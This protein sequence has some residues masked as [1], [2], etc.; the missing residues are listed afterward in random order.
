MPGLTSSAG[1]YPVA[2][3]N[4]H[5]DSGWTPMLAAMYP[6]SGVIGSV[7][8]TDLF[9]FAADTTNK[10]QTTPAGFKANIAGRLVSVSQIGIALSEP[11][12]TVERA[13]A[14]DDIFIDSDA[15]VTPYRSITPH[16]STTA[17][18]ADAI[19]SRAWLYES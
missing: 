5:I 19:D 3:A 17:N 14:F 10:F 11:E 6:H 7:D 8:K 12:S 15:V 16:R 2:D 4:G 18:D 13:V 9:F 1:K